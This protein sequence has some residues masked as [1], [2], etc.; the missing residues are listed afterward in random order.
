MRAELLLSNGSKRLH[1]VV[2]ITIII[3]INVIMINVITIN[4]IVFLVNVI[5]V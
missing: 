3:M 4:I 2:I 5:K 1:I